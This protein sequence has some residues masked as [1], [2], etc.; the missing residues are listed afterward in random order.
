M[1]DGKVAKHHLVSTVHR[2]GIKIGGLLPGAGTKVSVVPPE[3]G[4]DCQNFCRVEVGIH[5]W[6]KKRDTKEEEAEE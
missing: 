3:V 6:G 5:S 2:K 4:L 1:L